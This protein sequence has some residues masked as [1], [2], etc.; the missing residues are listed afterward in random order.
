MSSSF[1][2]WMSCWRKGLTTVFSSSRAEVFSAVTFT[3]I[4][5]MAMSGNSETGNVKYVT[6]PTIKQAV[7]AISTAM[8]RCIRKRIINSD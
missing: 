4:S 2:T 1:A 3:E 8:G 7:N 5:G 6:M